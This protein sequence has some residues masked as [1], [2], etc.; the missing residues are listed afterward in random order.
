MEPTHIQ[1]AQRKEGAKIRV[2]TGC[3]QFF[4]ARSPADAYEHTTGWSELTTCEKC[5]ARI[6]LDPD[7]KP[8]LAHAV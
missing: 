2:D 4:L 3:G 1:I 8:L 5:L 7:H 6:G